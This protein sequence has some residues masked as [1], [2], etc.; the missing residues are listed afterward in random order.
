M[1]AETE[2]EK[3]L[4]EQII[5]YIGNKR[6]LI[7]HIQAAV[8]DILRHLGKE[9]A[10]CGDL[11]S[12]SGV[13]ARMFKRY[14]DTLYAN[15]MESY[16]RV[17]NE[18]YLSN[19]K[20]FDAEKYNECLAVIQYA[21]A[22]R[23]QAGII[24]DN[25]APKSEDRIEKTD[26]CFYTP[27]NAKY[28]DTVRTAIDTI[29]YAEY[30]KYFLAPLLVEASVHSNTSGVFKGFY[31]D[32]KTNV[33]RYGGNGDNCLERITSNIA[34]KPPVLSR[35]ET[36]TVI[37]QGDTNTIV[38]ELEPL[39]IAYLDPPY[40]QHPYGSNYFMLN[41][42]VKN[43]L[44]G[45]LSEVSGIP[46][47]WNRSAYNK[48]RLIKG[49]FEDLI[50]NLNARFIIVSY[51]SEGFMT[52]QEIEDV[53]NAHGTTQTVSISYNTYRGCRNLRNREMHVDEY[54]FV[55]RKAGV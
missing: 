7:S 36:N 29:P 2:N 13:V 48:K 5:T 19:K 38:R 17:I 45:K 52:K 32:S 26:R 3:Y 28:I 1:N 6:K 39:D 15:D 47:D 12:G 25:Y 9:K 20:D 51:N 14:A 23:F 34:L 50:D 37:L 33:G 11:F 35:F 18:C 40:N 10:T 30:Q 41:T 53:L 55:L 24:A 16:S 21:L 42:I 49:T 8:E 43:E 54:L 4:T 22:H 31:K 27:Y 44:G 46:D